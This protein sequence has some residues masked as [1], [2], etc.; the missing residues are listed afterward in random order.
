MPR[1]PAVIRQAVRDLM[2]ASHPEQVTALIQAA[3]RAGVLQPWMY[4][5]LGIAMELDGHSKKDIERA[6]MS[7]ADFSTSAIE[8]MYIAQYLSRI[9]FDQRALGLY[10]QVVRID[11]DV[12]GGLPVGSAGSSTEATDIEGIQWATVGILSQAW[13]KE[14][15]AAPK[16]AY[17]VAN[18]TLEQLGKEG[19]DQRN[20]RTTNVSS[21]PP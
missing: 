11:R 9:G 4:E 21:R 19:R 17:R 16:V 1:D 15:A 5:S 12:P 8:L 2:G 7:A 13:P 10:Q 20:V 6:I 18:A 3:L 14:Q